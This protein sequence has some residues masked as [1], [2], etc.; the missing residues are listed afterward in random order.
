M[1]RKIWIPCVLALFGMAQPAQAT[2]LQDV[3]RICPVSENGDVAA[4]EF[5][6]RGYFA[7]DPN[8][9]SVM[10]FMVDRAT[11]LTHKDRTSVGE[12]R[13][14]LKAQSH[15]HQMFWGNLNF[16]TLIIVSDGP[17]GAQCDYVGHYD[18][19][20]AFEVSNLLPIAN[21]WET[22]TGYTAELKK[23][24]YAGQTFHAQLWSFD[25]GLR[26]GLKNPPVLGRTLVRIG[27]M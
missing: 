27:G 12:W 8:R 22:T 18:I 4:A 14:S 20:D 23:A 7:A 5:R 21:V 10:N 9:M 3:L 24:V 15:G 13:K 16:N 19:H 17:N 6:A 2:G 25:D 11:H 1:N 26:E